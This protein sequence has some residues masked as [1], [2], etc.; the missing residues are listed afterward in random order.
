[1]DPHVAML[2]GGGFMVTWTGGEPNGAG[3]E[4]YG[5]TYAATYEADTDAYQINTVTL[6][7]ASGHQQYAVAAVGSGPR[8]LIAWSGRGQPDHQG[9]YADVWEVGHVGGP[10]RDDLAGWTTDT[11]GGTDQGHGT[12]AAGAGKVVLI[13]G[14]SFLVTL[15]KS[16]TVPAAPSA[17]GMA[18]DNLQFDTTDPN[19]INDAFEI[20]LVDQDGNP[21]VP[22]YTP[23]RDAFFNISEGLSA[24]YRSGITF[25]GSVV[26]VG[27]SDLPAG[28]PVTLIFRLVNNDTD[29][30]TTVRITDFAVTPSTSLPSPRYSGERGGGE[31]LP[32]VALSPAPATSEAQ[33]SPHTPCADIGTRSVPI[34][35]GSSRHVPGR[36][37]ER[38]LLSYAIPFAFDYRPFP[39]QRHRAACGHQNANHRP[40]DSGDSDRS[41][42]H[43]HPQPHH[44]CPDQR[45]GRRRGRRRGQLLRPRAD[46]ARPQHVR[47]LGPGRLRPIGQHSVDARR[48]ATARRQYA[49]PVRRLAQLCRPVR[50]HLVRR[51][52]Q[53]AVCRTGDPQSGR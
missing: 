19:F 40:G 36:S 32:A 21:V 14:D 52:E 16:F 47:S 42:R 39:S 10:F 33:N 49:A 6:G 4:V 37:T 1:C 45:H 3:W 12:I 44:R 23:G 2:P 51:A 7:Y 24:A 27:L 13:E 38:R 43:Y 17:V 34:Y 26:T 9:V 46:P 18:F 29:H 41:E 35:F 22:P 53:A 5:R 28:L 15:A 20:A 48:L 31:G 8:A 25:D 30:T 50:S 11:S